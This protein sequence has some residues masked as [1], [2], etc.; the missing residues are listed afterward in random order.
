MKPPIAFTSAGLSST[1]P[2]FRSE[3][4][5]SAA[6]QLPFG[7]SQRW[8]SL[9][10]P[11][12]LVCGGVALAQPLDRSPA[13]IASRAAVR[14]EN[15]EQALGWI[16]VGNLAA[17]ETALFRNNI[18][19]PGTL[20]WDIESANRLAHAALVLRERSDY[21]TARLAA[22]RAMEHLATAKATRFTSS[23]PKRRARAY[24]AAG[25]IYERLLADPAAAKAAFAQ[26]EREFPG[27]KGARA[28]LDRIKDE[29]DKIAR[30]PG[31]K[32]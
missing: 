17:A 31:G 2:A 15:F 32:G 11:L 26:A 18:Q 6:P 20:E 8:R 3:G 25:F 5:S 19:Q 29:E 23:T 24:E 22:L 28:G 10:V 21:K 4:N 16:S 7:C 9:F 30:L 12:A 13:A 27:S 1:M 14:A